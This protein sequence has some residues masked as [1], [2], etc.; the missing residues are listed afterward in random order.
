[1][2]AL[3]NLQWA[4][5]ILAVVTFLTVWWGHVLVRIVHYYM[6]TRPAPVIFG[7]GLL[8]LLATTQTSNDLLGGAVGIVGLTL[9]WDA[10]ELHRQEARV[11]QGHAPLNPR[12]HKVAAGLAAAKLAGEQNGEYD[13]GGVCLSCGSN[14]NSRFLCR[15]GPYCQVRQWERYS[16]AQAQAVESREG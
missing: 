8:L 4:G 11:R 13:E 3:N 10:F 1:M 6:G 12:V 5:P 16:V 7:L 2:A 14:P 15:K 9:L